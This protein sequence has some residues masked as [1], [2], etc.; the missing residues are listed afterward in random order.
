[1]ETFRYLKPISHRQTADFREQIEKRRDAILRSETDTSILGKGKTYYVAA[2]GDDSADGMSEG[3]PFRTIRKINTLSLAP[4]DNVLFRRGDEWNE[5]LV[6]QMKNGVTYSAYGI[7]A[8]P[9][10]S[11]YIQAAGAESWINVGENLWVYSGSHTSVAHADYPDDPSLPGSYLISA[12]IDIIPENTDVG[13]IVFRSGEKTGWGAKITRYSR[14]MIGVGIG[15]VSLGDLGSL[16]REEGPFRD[17]HDLCSDF[18][19][20]HNPDQRRLYLYCSR[21]NPGELFD[22]IR[23]PVSGCL[24]GGECQ[25]V[26]VDNIEFSY[27]GVHGINIGGARNFT[28]RNCSFLWIGGSIQGYELWGN[29]DQKPVR[30]GNAF[31]NWGD[32]DGFR[33]LN[34]YV[35]Q[36]YDTAGGSQIWTDPR[37]DFCKMFGIVYR[38]N[39]FDHCVTAVEN[40]LMMPEGHK[41]EN[42]FIEYSVEDNMIV[43]TGYGFGATR[44][45]KGGNAFGVNWFCRGDVTN[46]LIFD[47]I[48][49]GALMEWDTDLNVR[50]ATNLF[51]NTIVMEYGMDL[52][53]RSLTA[54]SNP[55]T[56]AF[57]SDAIRDGLLG[58]NEFLFP[59][60]HGEIR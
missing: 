59:E 29:R 51:G 5:H 39:L 47:V 48:S 37:R 43:H 35:Y 55:Y 6:L 46:N 38:G 40:W 53:K 15:T 45:N 58:E 57:V 23:M 44:W 17:Q 50:E 9:A 1:M 60:D 20:F 34:N 22:D 4:G 3:T 25:D 24:A 49:Y 54:G 33:I 52:T 30:Y 10:L 31:Q 16:T 12:K 13:N 27:T 2:D 14:S 18:E 32:C 36:T 26:T 28:I 21:G 7:G 42:Y 19:F 41:R 56:D 8:K 11:N